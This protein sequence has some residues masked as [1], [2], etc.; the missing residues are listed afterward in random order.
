[1]RVRDPPWSDARVDLT[2]CAAARGTNQPLGMPAVLRLSIMPRNETLV[3]LSRMLPMSI[4]ATSPS[5]EQMRIGLLVPPC[6]PHSG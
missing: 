1:V 6:Q 2:G 4:S 3:V 5:Q